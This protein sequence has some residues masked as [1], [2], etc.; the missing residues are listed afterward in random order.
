MDTEA[1]LMATVPQLSTLTCIPDD[2]WR[3]YLYK[4]A[5]PGINFLRKAATKLG[6]SLDQLDSAIYQRRELI[7][8]QR[9][10]RN[11]INQLIKTGS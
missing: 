5:T 3:Q 4:E 11:E 8:K 6:M 9:Q 2:T 1:F 7:Q 10:I